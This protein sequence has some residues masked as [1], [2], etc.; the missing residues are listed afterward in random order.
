M[1]QSDILLS[2]HVINFPLP[3]PTSSLSF[4]L[5][6]LLSSKPR[7]EWWRSTS[8]SP[9][10]IQSY[11]LT[12]CRCMCVCVCV[13]VWEHPPWTSVPRQH[14]LMLAATSDPSAAS[15]NQWLTR[16]SLNS[17]LRLSRVLLSLVSTQ[18]VSHLPNIRRPTQQQPVQTS[19]RPAAFNF[20][21]CSQS[22]SGRNSHKCKYM[23][24]RKA[25][26]EIKCTRVLY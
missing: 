6:Q 21:N 2:R 22:A 12:V 19:C 20:L 26:N 5:S 1:S 11:N 18:S 14:D 24:F 4:S 3:S 25:N 16:V 8:R 7:A 23:R 13:C 10:T 17:I 9:A 15:M